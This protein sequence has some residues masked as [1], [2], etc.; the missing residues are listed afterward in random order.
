M[1]TSSCSSW[2]ARC[3]EFALFLFLIRIFPDS[4]LFPSIYG[5]VTTIA[6][7]L[8]SGNVGTLVGSTKRLQFVKA[9][10]VV[11]KISSSIAYALLLV[12]FLAPGDAASMEGRKTALF[13]LIT[14]AGS[15]L[16]LATVGISVAIERDWVTVRRSP[17]VVAFPA[18]TLRLVARLAYD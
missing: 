8:F 18:A 5:F 16:K 3:F 2:V 17:F 9:T 4:L 1:L 11:Q 10:I 12:L 15:I 7:I 6:A 13:V 14:I